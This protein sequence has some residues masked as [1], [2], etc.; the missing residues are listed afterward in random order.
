LD[1]VFLGHL[2]LTRE[3]FGSALSLDEARQRWARFQ[4]QSDVVMV[5]HPGTARLYSY[6]AGDRNPCLV[7][8]SVDLESNPSQPIVETFSPAQGFPVAA[9]EKTG[10]AGK[11]L[12]NTIAFVRHL[13]ALAKTRVREKSPLA[14]SEF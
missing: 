3:D 4:R 14:D 2:E 10:R 9:W 1:D 6:L 13:I 5:F 7:L 12:A 11:R 8:K